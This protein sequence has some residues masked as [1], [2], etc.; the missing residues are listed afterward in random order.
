MIN[1]KNRD[2]LELQ[3][4]LNHPQKCKLCKRALPFWKRYSRFCSTSCTAKYCNPKRKKPNRLCKICLT[5]ITKNATFC[6][7][8]FATTQYLPL[9]KIKTDKGRKTFL[10]RKNRHRCNKCKRI[11]WN[12]QKIPLELDHIDGNFKNNRINNLRLLCPNCHSQTPTFKGRNKGHGRPH[13]RR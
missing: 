3:K 5:T 9:H 8:C 12:D 2:D 1:S 10:I 7:P 13:R 11:T 6:S 4:Y